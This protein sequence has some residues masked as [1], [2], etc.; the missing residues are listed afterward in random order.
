LVDI[1][2]Q[3]R[4][5]EKLAEQHGSGYNRNVTDEAPTGQLPPSAQGLSG[6]VGGS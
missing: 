4:Y 5:G 6:Y 1:E 2:Y 3:R